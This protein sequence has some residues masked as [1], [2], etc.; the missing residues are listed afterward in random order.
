[1]TPTS[2]PL[3]SSGFYRGQAKHYA[4]L[5]LKLVQQQRKFTASIA[6][7]ISIDL[8]RVADLVESLE[9]AEDLRKPG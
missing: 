8:E 6:S 4:R 1:M 3:S 7:A 2:W 9:E 5:S